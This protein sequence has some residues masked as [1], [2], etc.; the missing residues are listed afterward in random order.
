MTQDLPTM[1]LLLTTM[2]LLL[3]S[4]A[5]ISVFVPLQQCNLTPTKITEY[6]NTGVVVF[7]QGYGQCFENTGAIKNVPERY[8]NWRL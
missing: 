2:I 4:G 6:I 3:T 8:G 1:I 7:N 5:G